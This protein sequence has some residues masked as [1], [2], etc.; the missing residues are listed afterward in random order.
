MGGTENL[1]LFFL[2]FLA[3]AVVVACGASRLRVPYTIAVVL[4]GST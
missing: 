3:M 2:R 4:A 1:L